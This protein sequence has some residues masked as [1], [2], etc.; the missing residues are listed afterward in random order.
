MFLRR[1]C[2]FF[3][4]LI[5]NN[6]IN[7]TVAIQPRDNSRME[8]NTTDTISDQNKDSINQTQKPKLSPEDLKAK[9][10][11]IDILIKLIQSRYSCLGSFIKAWLIGVPVLSYMTKKIYDVYVEKNKENASNLKKTV[12]LL[13]KIGCFVALG[14]SSLL[15][16]GCAVQ[17]INYLEEFF[18][19]K[20]VQE[21]T[22]PLLLDKIKNGVT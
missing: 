2:L 9:K 15:T 7:T 12:H 22:Q 14:F 3:V 5:L 20:T 10:E 17:G 4:M 6:Q 16:L 1:L 11:Q 13:K 21:I 19:A 18:V 8:N